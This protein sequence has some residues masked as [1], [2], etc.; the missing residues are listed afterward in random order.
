MGELSKSAKCQFNRMLQKC[1]VDEAKHEFSNFLNQMLR[2]NKV[3]FREYDI[4]ANRLDDFFMGYLKETVRYKNL[5]N[6]IKI[7]LTLS[8]GQSAVDKPY[9]VPI[10]KELMDNIRDYNMRYKTSVKERREAKKKNEK[11]EKLDDLN[12]ELKSLNDN[13]IFRRGCKGISE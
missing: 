1:S 13:K 7:V 4:D 9:N 3:I 6:V 8:H 12:M 11:D 5:L 2:E 10:T